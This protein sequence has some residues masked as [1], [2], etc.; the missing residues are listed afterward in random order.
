MGTAAQVGMWMRRLDKTWETATLEIMT[1]TQRKWLAVTA[2]VAALVLIGS[3]FLF[4]ASPIPS[5]APLVAYPAVPLSGTTS[6]QPKIT[7]STTSIN[8]I[9]SPGE[10]TS[11]DL[12]FTSSQKLTNVALTVVPQIAPFVNVQPSSISSLA[13][14]QAQSV[15]LAIAI[16]AATAFGTYDGT[17]QLKSGTTTFP[18]TVKITVNVWQVADTDLNL[19]FKFPSFSVPSKVITQATGRQRVDLEL[20]VNPNQG[21]VSVAGMRIYPNPLHLSLQEWFRQ[22]LDVSDILA[23]DGT[24][25]QRTLS[26]GITV[27]VS[28]GGL[29]PEYLDQGGPIEYAFAKSSVDDRVIGISHAQDYSLS[30][31]G[32]SQQAANDLLIQILST[33]RLF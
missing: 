11:S 19:S 20:M 16:A 12:T 22:T 3:Q 9:L 17:I 5:A 7:W 8:V 27:L 21:F 10:S 32:Y 13:A 15:H 14:N 18:Q 2:S 4:G 33:L 24:F 23:N 29:P 26:N 1:D 31:F 6:T 30:D 28:A 25:Q